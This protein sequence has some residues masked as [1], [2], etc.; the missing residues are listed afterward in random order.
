ML[1]Q[2]GRMFTSDKHKNINNLPLE[3]L[4][5]IF[6][7]IGKDKFNTRLIC[8]AFNN[9]VDEIITEYKLVKIEYSEIMIESGFNAKLVNELIK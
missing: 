2:I 8:H 6:K 4:E 1:V 3:I 7:Y 9:I 5:Y